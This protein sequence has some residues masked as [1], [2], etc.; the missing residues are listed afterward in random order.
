MPRGFLMI[1]R[2]SSSES[3][4]RGIRCEE[5][6]D[7]LNEAAA[8]SG[9]LFLDPSQR[10][11]ART[12]SPGAQ[13]L[14]GKTSRALERKSETAAR[15]LEFSKSDRSSDII[16]TCLPEATIHI[17]KSLRQTFGATTRARRITIATS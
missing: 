2:S 10:C 14:Q 7:Y 6:C 11:S 9:P 17:I 13:A 8:E 16:L 3:R 4:R 15:L 5:S 1:A 12:A